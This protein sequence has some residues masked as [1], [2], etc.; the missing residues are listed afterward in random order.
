[1]NGGY[2]PIC[3]QMYKSNDETEAMRKLAEAH[4]CPAYGLEG[5]FVL[6]GERYKE[7][8]GL[9]TRP[10][11]CV[12]DE[13]GEIKE[14]PIKG[15]LRKINDEFDELKEAILGK[16]YAQLGLLMCA[17]GAAKVPRMLDEDARHIA[18]EAADTITAITTLL[19]AL[20]I[21]ADARDEAQRQVNR[22]NRER[23]RL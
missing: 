18:E 20:G 17:G 4:V 2:I 10:L 12:R 22:K 5:E 8:K 23:R 16:N 19:E 14:Q 13:H 21:D 9:G 15:L 1:M 3:P 6:C 7:E 11:P